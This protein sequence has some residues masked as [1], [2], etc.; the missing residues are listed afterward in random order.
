M[1]PAVIALALLPLAACGPEES[2][3]PTAAVEPPPE[4]SKPPLV[5]PPAAPVDMA[6]NDASGVERLRLSCRADPPVLH[7]V[8]PGFT[9]IG[10]EDRLTLGAGDEAFAHVADL[11]ASGPGVVGGGPIDAD[12]MARLGRGEPVSAVYGA[13]TIG[14]LSAAHPDA[15][16][17]FAERCRGLAGA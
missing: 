11:D 8:V 2:A 4:P 14:P 1:R 3:A 12:L 7:I 15:V 10:S 16:A 17:A 9:P 6:F 13:Q 5:E